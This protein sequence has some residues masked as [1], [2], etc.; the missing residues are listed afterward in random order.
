MF[1]ILSL[2]LIS[3]CLLSSFARGQQT[4]STVAQ[5]NEAIVIER[6]STVVSFENDG[7]GFR[8]TTIAMRMQSDAGPQNYGV[9][10]FPYAKENE[11]LE[12]VYVRV[13]K[14]DGTIVTTPQE[15]VQDMPEEVSRGAPM[16]SD[17]R[18]KQVAV[19]G[20]STGDLLE[21]QVRTRITRPQVSGEFWYIDNF[22]EDAITKQE[23]LEV[24]VPADREVKVKSPSLKPK[25]KDSEGKRVY[26]WTT[27]NLAVDR[28]TKNRK[29]NEK[30]PEPKEPSVQLSTVRRW[31]DIGRWYDALQK[32]RVSV[33]Q[34]ISARA[35]ELTKAA[36]TDEEKLRAIYQFVATRFRYVSISFGIGRYQPHH[37]SEVLENEYGDCKDKHTLMAALLKAA[38]IE[39]MPALVN[40]TGK[41]DLEVPSMGQFNHVITYVKL[42]EKE[43]WLDSTPEI[44]PFAFVLGAIRGKDALVIGEEK[45]QFVKVPENPPFPMS[46]R[47]NIDAKLTTDGTLTGKVER[48]VRGDLEVILRAAFRKTPRSQWQDVV[49][50]ISYASGYAGPVSNVDADP[51][52]DTSK[53]FRWTY[54]YTRKNFGDWENRRI[55]TAL[56][57]GFGIEVSEIDSDKPERPILLGDIGEAVFSSRLELP[58]GY[59][60]QAP[61]GLKISE[62]FADYESTYKLEANVLI[63]ER[64]LKVKLKEVPV[65]AWD[66][67]QKFSKQ[68]SDEESQWIDLRAAREVAR[69]AITPDQDALFEKARQAFMRRDV[70]DVEARLQEL[71]KLNDQY[72]GLWMGLGQVRIIRGDMAGG[73]AMARKE[74][75]VHPFDVRGYRYLAFLYQGRNEPEEAI[76]LWEELLTHDPE[77]L[78]AHS[79]LA[80]LLEKAGKTPEALRHL[81]VAAKKAP[82]D[83]RVLSRIGVGYIKV[84]RT[85][86]GVKALDRA[87]ELD[88]ST[89][90]S[91][92]IAYALAESKLELERAKEFALNAVERTESATLDTV[93]ERVTP[94]QLERVASLGSYWETLGWIYFQLEDYTK[95]EQYLRAAWDLSQSGVCAEH[96]GQLYE[97][98]AMKAE[99]LHMYRLALAGPRVTNREVLESKVKSLGGIPRR[100]GVPA[101]IQAMQKDMEAASELSKLRTVKLRH[102][103]KKGSAEYYIL[104]NSEGSVEDVRKISGDA[105]LKAAEE[106]LK[107]AK[108]DAYFPP[109]SKV[110]VVRRCMVVC[111]ELASVG[112]SAVLLIPDTVRDVN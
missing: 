66:R 62:D 45:S 88:S 67:F 73:I 32:E 99:A 2:L 85:E 47:F 53:P 103:A 28:V 92:N 39:A 70:N 52:E 96:L 35:K 57:P 90:I 111:S 61:P 108:Y 3:T 48:M 21:Y 83:A 20:L 6:L 63:G 91:N 11:E 80:T 112:C 29:K 46:I 87:V 58:A 102:L 56:P 94:G 101:K 44:A 110:K 25:V 16:Y 89:T 71:K 4:P 13:R 107:R 30:E 38:G 42:G 18:E 86:D 75:D 34:A 84:G 8:E 14:P 98:R 105:A 5:D 76:K 10:T 77:N 104:M 69:P 51:P 22:S 81:E 95:A 43:Y 40:T 31:E 33:T 82:D 79:E 64:R 19:R 55:H 78:D 93:L 65:E 60:I 97:R 1:R 37:A 23:T 49:Q 72:P 74:V 54:E 15:Y 26:T 106:H 109:D 7:K 41:L 27:E 59:S 100:K 50:A 17:L 9:L 24:R 12:I 36:V 68:L